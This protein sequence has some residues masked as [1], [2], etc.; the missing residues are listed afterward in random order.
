MNLHVDYASRRPGK[1]LVLQPPEYASEAGRPHL[2]PDHA[3]GARCY[4]NVT[5][6]V[7]SAYR[8][9][10]PVVPDTGAP[11]RIA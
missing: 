6:G 7:V 8:G 4:L 9:T 2:R 5:C 1:T 3:T 11:G 10:V